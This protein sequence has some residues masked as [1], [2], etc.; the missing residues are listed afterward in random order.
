MDFIF[1]FIANTQ[2][3]ASQLGAAR[4]AFSDFGSGARNALQQLAGDAKSNVAAVTTKYE[5][6]RT[7]V[8]D[9]RKQIAILRNSPQVDLMRMLGTTNAADTAAEVTRRVKE[10]N[11]AI[12]ENQVKIR[13][14]VAESKRFRQEETALNKTIQLTTN[15]FRAFENM[16]STRLQT[17]L[18]NTANAINLIRTT[19]GALARTLTVITVSAAAFIAAFVP[20]AKVG[21]DFEQS[22]SKIVSVNTELI[23]GTSSAS[24][25]IKNVTDTILELGATTNFTSSEVAEAGRVLAQ[26]GLST[27]E[28]I[29]AL[30]ATLNLA[31]AGFIELGEA[32]SVAADFMNA[33]GLAGW[34]ISRV[35][36]TM[37]KAQAV[38][39]TN[40]E[41]LTH[42]FS[43]AS[44]T[45]ASFGQRIEDVAIGL[46]ALANSG[47]K[48]SRA[49]TGISQIMS[50]LSKDAAKTDAFMR[51]LGSSFE[52]VNPS[53]V[54]FVDIIK[55]FQRVG[56]EAGD[57][58]KFF[59]V[60]AGRTMLALQ[61]V[62]EETLAD[63]EDKINNAFGTAIDQAI[64][65]WDNLAGSVKQFQSIVERL[66]LTFFNTFK[67]NL[68]VGIDVVVDA[69]RRLNDFLET[70]PLAPII[71]GAATAGV[72]LASLTVAVGA[73]VTP[74][75]L[76]AASVAGVATNL[77]GL[78]ISTQAATSSMASAT[79]AY[80]NATRAAV[81]NIAV[82][83]A[84]IITLRKEAAA[85]KKAGEMAE[86]HAIME[87]RALAIQNRSRAMQAQQQ[88]A[89]Q[90]GNLNTASGAAGASFGSGIADKG[91]RAGKAVG[92]AVKYAA[93]RGPVGLLADA[94]NTL[95][96][97]AAGVGALFTKL[98]ATLP[99]LGSIVAGVKTAVIG[100]TSAFV[101]GSVVL[102][103]LV[104]LIGTLTAAFV[105]MF[106][107]L[108]SGD[109]ITA[110]TKNIETL[111][112]ILEFL[113]S[114]WDR[115]TSA[116]MSGFTFITQLA[117]DASSMFMEWVNMLG[118]EMW[119]TIL[120]TVDILGTMGEALSL[121]IGLLAGLAGAVILAGIVVLTGVLK[122]LNAI[123]KS[124]IWGLNKIRGWVGLTP[125]ADG[126]D[127]LTESVSAS[128]EAIEKYNEKMQSIRDE[129]DRTASRLQEFAGL[130]K[131]VGNLDLLQGE[132]LMELLK[133]FKDIPS[134]ISATEG[135]ISQ[136]KQD[137]KDTRDAG[138]SE[139][140]IR[141]R[142][143]RLAELEKILE[144][145]NQAQRDNNIL[146]R[147]GF[148]GFQQSQAAK[149]EEA[150][151]LLEVE[152]RTK[153][154]ERA[155]KELQSL[156][157]DAA[158]LRSKDINDEL[159]LLD[160]KIIK[161]KEEAEL[162]RSAS[163]E[164]IDQAEAAHAAKM[165]QND[166]AFA[167]LQQESMRV[168]EGVQFREDEF[169]F[170]QKELADA[171]AQRA[172]AAKEFEDA[173][174]NMGGPFDTEIANKAK[175]KLDGLNDEVNAYEN[176]LKKSN[177][178]LAA[179]HERR[180]AIADDANKLTKDR[181]ALLASAP[182]TTTAKADMADAAA[183]EAEAIRQIQEKQ[184]EMLREQFGNE[185]AFLRSQA[186]EKA[187]LAGDR[188]KA[189]ELE[190]EAFL[191]SEQERIDKEFALNDA[192]TQARKRQAFKNMQDIA[193]AK[194]Q[195]VK[196]DVAADAK[197]EAE[198]K[199]K[200]AD[201]AKK[202]KEDEAKKRKTPEDDVRKKA[203]D[204]LASQ[205]QST[206]QL[207]ALN[208]ALDILE[209]RRE[210]RARQ[211][212]LLYQAQKDKLENMLK[213]QQK[214]AAA[215]A[216]S[217]TLANMAKG[218]EKIQSA[219]MIAKAI[220]GKKLA[221]AGIVEG[222]ASLADGFVGG[223]AGQ[224]GLA[225]AFNLAS[226]VMANLATALQNFV[227]NLAGGGNL[228]P[229]AP[230]TALQNAVANAPHAQGVTNINTI[231]FNVKNET[232][233]KKLI[234][235]IKGALNDAAFGPIP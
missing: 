156:Y 90:A 166:D 127:K 19:T 123:I 198:K 160:E 60:R 20:I 100:L 70:S 18:Q 200:E 48:A 77:I 83:D 187:Q 32:A 62:S 56:L 2:Q 182:D 112:G 124:I 202:K 80:E 3:L 89:L 180:K 147:D 103:P 217:E 215:G 75:L 99:T 153:E 44:A 154:L 196:D 10:L 17:T 167:Y 114:V 115:I 224:G 193:D 176:R 36:D 220:A 231:T 225:S 221:N 71:T 67:G 76:V 66:G 152:R 232:D 222:A 55:E 178:A 94:F 142:T 119:T 205:V 9:L 203:A 102:L 111:S 139:N 211:A 57:A 8:A 131:D 171:K 61:N 223:D 162:I 185:K 228:A 161:I 41:Q 47:I 145:L 128:N 98:G 40:I 137:I 96:I 81:E 12:A 79:L 11:L 213:A 229:P 204:H 164:K 46:A 126:F 106:T 209:N 132:R 141:A 227:A 157:R 144:A 50:A 97:S 125:I 42:A 186:I 190:W 45:A 207:L 74:L 29:S 197:K 27:S 170:L 64:N 234:S 4:Q 16:L 149:K 206:A 21:I 59:G 109:G 5:G 218:I 120:G 28:I 208:S 226:P 43:F 39:N 159:A 133:T 37:A 110:T 1:N 210:G 91:K 85:Q 51:K 146:T 35:A 130:V 88:L 191:E 26:A 121:I 172:A 165:K 23:S 105:G 14:G 86:Y 52:A 78:R 212:V 173:V 175:T 179:L 69:L 34:E 183:K 87:Q 63:L 95:M 143:E 104:A 13:G 116:F 73:V 15:A 188:I 107:S 177:E 201:A 174:R 169:A 122:V 117:G 138:G 163:Q 24:A 134:A 68:K 184:A 92:D 113:G 54:G 148:A 49:G 82:I 38:S 118:T 53:A 22:I 194:L 31:N 151:L 155:E 219:A 168:D 150:A 233:G 189:A 25:A 108:K 72:V 140:D 195:A 199:K 129:A 101:A 30:P 6:L 230:G 216:S 58:F 7:S 93:A 214:A 135:L 136:I 235:M 65:N 84:K 33:F 192:A 181:G 158:G